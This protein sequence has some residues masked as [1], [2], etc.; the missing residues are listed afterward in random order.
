MSDYIYIYMEKIQSVSKEWVNVELYST[1]FKKYIFVES[2]KGEQIC[3]SE[4]RCQIVGNNQMPF[5]KAKL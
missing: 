4:N 3:T 2:K 5:S 1:S